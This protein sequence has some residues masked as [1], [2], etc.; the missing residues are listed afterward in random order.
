MIFS[1][2]MQLSRRLLERLELKLISHIRKDVLQLTFRRQFDL[3][4]VSVNEKK[5]ESSI[6]IYAS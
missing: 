2:M 4:L 5:H 3:F 1:V 6:L